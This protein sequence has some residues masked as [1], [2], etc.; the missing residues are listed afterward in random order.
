MSGFIRRRLLLSRR[1]ARSTA[2]AA[3]MVLVAGSAS[4]AAAQL[5]SIPGKAAVRP[6]G[7]ATY[8]MPIMLPPGS[9]GLAPTLAL[10]YNSQRG[11]GVVGMGWALSGLPAITRCPRTRAQDGISGA[12]K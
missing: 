10:D 4:P 12:V 6:T 8:T 7:A 9:G 2:A 11:N 3:L 1:I 5:M